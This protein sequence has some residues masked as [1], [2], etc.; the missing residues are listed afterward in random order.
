MDLNRLFEKVLLESEDPIND[1]M[2]QE[3]ELK[4]DDAVV[5]EVD[6]DDKATLMMD[7]FPLG[8]GVAVD[9]YCQGE[10]GGFFKRG[11]KFVVTFTKI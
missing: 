1:E 2:K 4:F 10:F 9:V 7:A 5:V 11:E 6:G 3:N 8:H